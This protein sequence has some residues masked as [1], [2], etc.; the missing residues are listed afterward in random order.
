MTIKVNKSI[1]LTV[2]FFFFSNIFG[3]LNSVVIFNLIVSK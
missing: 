3:R 1:M 2:S